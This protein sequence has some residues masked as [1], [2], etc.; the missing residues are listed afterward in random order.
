LQRY[1]ALEVYLGSL[2]AE[3]TFVSFW[4]V[5]TKDCGTGHEGLGD[6]YAVFAEGLSK[7]SR[8][9]SEGNVLIFPGILHLWFCG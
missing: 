7:V 4:S 6:L 5:V 2:K 9:R 3:A 1:H 8:E